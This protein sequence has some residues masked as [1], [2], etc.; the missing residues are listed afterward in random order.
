MKENMIFYTIHRWLSFLK[1]G[2]ALQASPPLYSNHTTVSC[3]ILTL[4][5]GEGNIYLYGVTLDYVVIHII[6]I[7]VI[8]TE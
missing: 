4:G 7:A 1:K 2:E 8:G 5:Q 3:L 6:L